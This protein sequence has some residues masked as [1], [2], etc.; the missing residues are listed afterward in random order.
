MSVA[1]MPKRLEITLTSSGWETSLGIRL[2][3]LFFSPVGI[4]DLVDLVVGEVVVEVV[5]YL[6]GRSPA[7]DADAFDFFKREEA[8]GG[9]TFVADAEL[10]L[11]VFEEIVAAA[12]H[13]ADVG[14]DLYVVLAGGL[15][16]QHGIV[17][18][19]VADVERRDADAR[20]DFFDQGVGEISDLVL[21]VE[22]HGD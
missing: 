6:N 11:Q 13:A 9:D 22:Q 17:A 3:S 21:G 14:A 2:L 18:G 8:V 5:V 7:A 10:I 16:A 19:H 1:P 15:E 4:Q 12:Q 20:G